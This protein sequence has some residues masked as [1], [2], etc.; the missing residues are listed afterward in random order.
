MARVLLALD[1]AA[2]IA[3]AGLGDPELDA[4][5]IIET[6]LRSAPDRR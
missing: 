3:A 4:T 2:D 1:E 5:R 6:Y